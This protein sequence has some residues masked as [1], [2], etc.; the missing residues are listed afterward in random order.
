LTERVDVVVGYRASIEAFPDGFNTFVDMRRS[1]TAM[2]PVNPTRRRGEAWI[3]LEALVARSSQG[4]RST[5]GM[6]WAL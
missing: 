1:A 5:K 3:A 2:E 4:K 6:A